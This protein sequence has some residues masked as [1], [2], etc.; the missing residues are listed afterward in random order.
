MAQGFFVSGCIRNMQAKQNGSPKRGIKYDETARQVLFGK[1]TGTMEQQHQARD[2]DLMSRVAAG[3]RAAFDIL[4]RRHLNRIYAIARC[5]VRAQSDA[6]DV[7]QEVFTRLW[8]YGPKWQEGKSAFT[9]WLY[10][11]VVNC[12]NDHLR[13][14][15]RDTS[16]IPEDLASK[17][18]DSEVLLAE[19]QQQAKVRAALNTLPERQRLA[20]TLC[21]FEGMTNPEAAEAMDLHIKALEGLLVR[22]RKSMKGMLEEERAKYG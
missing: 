9:T 6:E 19:R 11:I 2:E 3:D 17:E 14:F 10:R 8:V 20:V 18:P 7:A 12:C 5:M 1:R 13:K 15:R 21:Y 4:A 16:E 22:A